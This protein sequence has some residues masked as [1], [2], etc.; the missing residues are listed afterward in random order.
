LV[1]AEEQRIAL[2]MADLGALSG[3]WRPGVDEQ[4]LGNGAGVGSPTFTPRALLLAPA[5]VLVSFS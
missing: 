2:P 1:M 4:A 5:Q 3:G